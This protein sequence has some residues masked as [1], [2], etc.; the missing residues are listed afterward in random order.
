VKAGEHDKVR[1]LQKLVLRSFSNTLESV[2][3]VTQINAGK[4]S[5]GMDQVIVKTAK[6]KSEL[7]QAV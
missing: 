1:Q 6:G 2:R 5:A 3:R 7:A 4:Y